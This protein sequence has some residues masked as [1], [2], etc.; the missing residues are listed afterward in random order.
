[1][2]KQDKIDIA[3]NQPLVAMHVASGLALWS[4]EGGRHRYDLFGMNSHQEEEYVTNC[5]QR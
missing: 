4:R 1:M 5:F 3:P 2:E